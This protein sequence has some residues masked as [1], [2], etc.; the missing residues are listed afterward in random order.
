LE[1][2]QIDQN[3]AIS[4]KTL[5]LAPIESPILQMVWKELEENVL[6]Q[7]P[8]YQVV[9]RLAEADPHLRHTLTWFASELRQTA[10]KF[11]QIKKSSTK[12]QLA[13]Y[14]AIDSRWNTFPVL[15]YRH[16]GSQGDAL[17]QD[18][19]ESFAQ[20]SGVM[21]DYVLGDVLTNSPARRFPVD[22]KDVVRDDRPPLRR[23]RQRRIML[24]REPTKTEGDNDDRRGDVYVEAE[25]E[26]VRAQGALDSAHGKP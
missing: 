20:H 10:S 5:E 9:R 21:L 23:R 22:A 12:L 6:D 15:A 13:P 7:I 8:V 11:R 17:P 14:L 25:V 1:I 2:P 18:D 4:D 26:G 3:L 19:L 16:Q 24:K